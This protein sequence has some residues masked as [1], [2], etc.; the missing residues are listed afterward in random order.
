MKVEKTELAMWTA[1]INDQKQ[2]LG[3]LADDRCSDSDKGLT[4]PSP[5]DGMGAAP[6]S[7][8]KPSTETL[9]H[10]AS[11]LRSLTCAVKPPGSCLK[12]LP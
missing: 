8:D 5:T 12:F 9:P 1:Q 10:F 2:K 6:K 7:K 11:D 4:Q 3:C